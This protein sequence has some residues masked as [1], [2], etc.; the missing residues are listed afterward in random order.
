M[1]LNCDV[2][3][4]FWESLGLQGDQISQ[5]K[6]KSVPNIHWR[7][8]CWSWNSNTLAIWFEKPTHWKRSWCWEGLKAGG[9]GDDRGW[10]GWMASPTRWTWVWIGSGNWWCTG[11]PG[12]LQSMGSQRLRHSWATELNWKANESAES[13]FVCQK[14]DLFILLSVLGVHIWISETFGYDY[15]ASL[16]HWPHGRFGSHGHPKQRLAAF[17]F[18]LMEM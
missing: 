8:W 12:M 7:D 1:L 16:P 6:R 13:M 5:S 15:R 17:F 4:D 11:K 14:G 2:G 3:E 18:F 10:D 9:E